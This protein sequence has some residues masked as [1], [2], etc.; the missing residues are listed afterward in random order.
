MSLK[1]VGFGLALLG[2]ACFAPAAASAATENIFC[3]VNFNST[4]PGSSQTCGFAR[5]FGEGRDGVDFN[6]SPTPS[7]VEGFVTGGSGGAVSVAGDG[8]NLSGVANGVSGFGALHAFASADGGGSALPSFA[9]GSSETDLGF[10]DW[11]IVPGTSDMAFNLHARVLLEGAFGSA[12]AN[13]TGFAF[14]QDNGFQLI[15]TSPFVSVGGPTSQQDFDFQVHGGDQLGFYMTISA[16]ANVVGP[17]FSSVADL[18]N[19]GALF[20]DLTDTN[21]RLQ[22]A[23]GHD[24]SLAPT[25]SSGAPEPGVWAMMLL[26]FAGLGLLRR[27]SRA[28][29]VAI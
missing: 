4:A 18:S 9:H 22:T 12:T 29:R 2:A 25:S 3:P 14:L 11:A 23:S 17:V 8:G 7:A 24:Y 16:Q 19:T 5:V 10:G 27:R 28:T 20:L 6:G 15:N 26:G 21:L 1:N 13:G